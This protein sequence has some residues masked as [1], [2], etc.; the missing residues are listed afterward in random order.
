MRKGGWDS[1]S[2]SLFR[3]AI[4]SRISR[5]TAVKAVIAI[6][7]VFNICYLGQLRGLTSIYIERE[8]I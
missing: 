4:H 3:R 5:E 2:F 1:S 7:I 8:S 6:N